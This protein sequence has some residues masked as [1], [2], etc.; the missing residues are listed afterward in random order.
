MT[1]DPPAP[2]PLRREL[3]VQF[4]LPFAAA[5]LLAGVGL[6]LI[7]PLL[8]SPTDGLLFIL[9]LVV[10][11]LVILAVYGGALLRRHVLGPLERLA[12]DAG[13]IA[14]GEYHHR[15]RPADTEEMQAVQE[16][17][18]RMADR[19]LADQRL[20]AENVASLERTNRELVEARNQV[21]H[22]ARLASVGTL[23]AGLAHEVGNPLGAIMA[24]VDVARQ[25]AKRDG[26]DTEILDSIREEAE[27]IDRIVRGLLDYA[28]PRGEAFGAHSPADVVMRVRKLLENQGKLDGIETTWAVVGDVPDVVMEPHRLE[29]VLVNL[30]LNAVD[31]LRGVP[32]PQISVQL[33]D[34]DGG[35]ARLPIR[36]AAD[37]EGVNYLHR[38]RVARDDGG[39][40]VDPLFSAERVAVL[41]VDDNG[42]GIPEDDLLRVFDPFY[43]T[44]EPGKGTGLGLSICARLVEGMGGRIEARN[45]P[46]GGAS[47]IIRLPGAGTPA[48]G[49][50]ENG[51]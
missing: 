48:S 3:L 19:L 36:R 6:G 24:Y 8:P 45:R 28:R 41:Q 17:V 11:D 51:P 13:R 32:D 15:F 1:A 9:G 20:L 38:R 7:L 29:Q 25:R 5:I 21:I 26:Q 30:L 23:A 4:G 44:K 22:A 49:A 14:A 31:A 46:E 10:A 50:G 33:Y 37:P 43:T 27:R 18:S 16:A 35:I 12:E 47:F 42:P 39:R 34:D 40:G 2:A